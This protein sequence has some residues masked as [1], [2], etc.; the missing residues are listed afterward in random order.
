[1]FR[2]K[3]KNPPKFKIG[4]I[5]FSIVHPL[6]SPGI[7]GYKNNYPHIIL[8]TNNKG[9]HY[10]EDILSGGKIKQRCYD[11]LVLGVISGDKYYDKNTE[12]VMLEDQ[13]EKNYITLINSKKIIELYR[14]TDKEGLIKP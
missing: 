7:S 5:C 6:F 13:F 14:N 9:I 3:F 10:Y 4:D 1:M 8:V 11:F 2:P 12:D